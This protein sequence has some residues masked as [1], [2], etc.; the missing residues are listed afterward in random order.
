MSMMLVEGFDSFSS[1]GEPDTSG[2]V[3]GKLAICVRTSMYEP[4]A[5]SVGCQSRRQ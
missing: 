4:R 5:G 3:D 2:E 1:G